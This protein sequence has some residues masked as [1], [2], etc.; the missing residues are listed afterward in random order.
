MGVVTTVLDALER[1]MAR[2]TPTLNKFVLFILIL[3]IGFLAGKILSRLVRK[4]MTDA[5]ADDGA[6]KRLGF[7]FSIT[8]AVSGTIAGVI[9]VGSVFLALTAIG[10]ALTVIQIALLIVVIALVTSTFLVLKDLLPN[11]VAG[12][13]LRKT[14]KQGAYVRADSFEGEVVSTSLLETVIV[15]RRGDTLLIPNS[16]LKKTTITLLKRKPAKQGGAEQ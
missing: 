10:F 13:S 11:L 8:K 16:V 2:I 3:F 7:K 15:S 14:I 12:L 1:F 6:R 5:G 9:Y 4:V